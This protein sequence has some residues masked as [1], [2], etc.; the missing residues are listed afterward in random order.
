[1]FHVEVLGAKVLLCHVL[2]QCFGHHGCHCMQ[3]NS[4]ASKIELVLSFSP[5]SRISYRSLQESEFD[6]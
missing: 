2:E 4:K 3:T 5:R 1:M 6:F